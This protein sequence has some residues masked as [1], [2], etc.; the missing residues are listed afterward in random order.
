VSEAGEA[1]VIE[2]HIERGVA[3]SSAAE[4][5]GDRKLRILVLRP[6]AD[7][8]AIAAD[9]MLPHR[10]ATAALAEARARHIPYDFAMDAAD[11]GAQ[12]CSEVA[13]A[14][15]VHC[16][17]HLWPG[18]SSISSPG[19]AA[20]LS[21]FGVRH[22][23]TQEPSDLEYDPQLVCVAEWRDADA[24]FEDHIDNA[25]VDVLLERAEAGA[26]LAY[27]VAALPLAR[28]AKGLLLEALGEVGPVP[29][30][31]SATAALK[32]QRFASDHGE[33]RAR[34]SVRAEEF[35]REHGYRA[36]YWELVRLAREA[37]E[38]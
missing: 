1:A 9:P 18:G 8:S 35:Q 23:D 19:I 5:L 3:V 6:R 36:P 33:L 4:Y 24:L 29:D 12:F 28:V 37:R 26:G 38:D 27:D 32:N 7:L 2:A 17:V 11:P 14:A 34:L 21:A 22:F 20:W 31:M 30:G 15:Y 13:S 25:V 10:A 16:G